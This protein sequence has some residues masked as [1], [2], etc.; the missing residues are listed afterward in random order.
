RAPS[1]DLAQTA[2]GRTP[3]ANSRSIEAMT[4]SALSVS[5]Q[6]PFSIDADVLVVGVQSIDGSPRLAADL[7]ELT[8]LSGQLS[9]MGVTG[10][11]DELTR[12]PGIGSARSVA[13]IG[14]GSEITAKSLRYAAGSAA[15]Q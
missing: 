6:S 12:L 11:A 1:G 3:T 13:L 10:G 9:G 7:P 15:R 2:P 14:L 5:S 4:V 8:S